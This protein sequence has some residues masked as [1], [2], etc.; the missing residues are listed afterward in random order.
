M[1]RSTELHRFQ[2]KTLITS[3]VSDFL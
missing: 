1:A 2:R 3:L